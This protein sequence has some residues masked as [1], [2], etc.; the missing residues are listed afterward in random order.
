MMII[1]VQQDGTLLV[2]FDTYHKPQIYKFPNWPNFCARVQRM[3]LWEHW[4][5]YSVKVVRGY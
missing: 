2:F 1:E 4:P 5:G 3:N